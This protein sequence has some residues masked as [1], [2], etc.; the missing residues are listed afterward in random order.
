VEDGEIAY[1]VHEVTIAGNLR[2][3]FKGIRAVGTD[4]D[5]RGSIRCGSVLIEGLTVAGT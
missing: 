5:L 4:V 1:P 3:I 2:K